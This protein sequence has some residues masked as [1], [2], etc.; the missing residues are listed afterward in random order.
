MYLQ[1][2]YYNTLVTLSKEV[3]REG[4][5]GESVRLLHRL[6]SAFPGCSDAF[7]LYGDA[8]LENGQG[9]EAEN[10][11][12]RSVLI[13]PGTPLGYLN[14]ARLYIGLDNIEKATQ[15]LL[16][17][18]KALDKLPLSQLQQVLAYRRTLAAGLEELKQYHP[19]LI[20][21]E[22]C[23]E[24]EPNDPV[25]H[26]IKGA[27]LIK[28]NRVDEAEVALL[29]SFALDPSS[30][31]N[32]QHLV[33][34]Y[35]SRGVPS[36]ALQYVEKVSKCSPLEKF[37]DLALLVANCFEAM[38]DS[39]TA[40][41]FLKNSLFERYDERIS[42]RVLLQ[43]SRNKPARERP[44]KDRRLLV[45]VAD[46]VRARSMNMAESL[47]AN[48]WKVVMLCNQTP[49]FSWQSYFDELHTYDS[50]EHA[51][52]LAQEYN[53]CAYHIF[54]G[55][56]DV[57]SVNFIKNKPG[58][59]IFD[60][61]DFIEGFITQSYTYHVGQLQHFCMEN[62]DAICARDL[63]CRYLVKKLGYS[64]SRKTIF[65]SDYCTARKKISIPLSRGDA[66]NIHVVCCGS[67]ATSKSSLE[68]DWG[69]AAIARKFIEHGIHFHL[70]PHPAQVQAKHFSEQ[71]SDFIELAKKTPL[72]KLHDP[73]PMDKLA[74][75]ISQYH[76]GINAAY[77]LTDIPFISSYTHAH[78]NYC[79]SA[80]NTEYL[81]AGLP[82]LINGDRHRFQYWTFNRM[83]VA[84]DASKAFFDN[85]REILT[86]FA[87]NPSVVGDIENAQRRYSHET[88]I[89]R[90]I[91]FYEDLG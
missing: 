57:L 8:L 64:L 4:N 82:L 78:F 12:K 51:L 61:Y 75:E 43:I 41:Q 20:L 53:P 58:K 22:T 13:D 60:A 86:Q 69:Y 67:I 36:T 23:R 42:K 49:F 18:A 45:F 56:A 85:P 17:G 3:S 34:L 26:R 89:P 33:E 46:Q 19:A 80:R 2:D 55:N 30:I 88:H 84:I 52:N 1:F 27:L 44:P 28:L 9:E 72:F 63:R 87:R 48:G 59:I 6:T 66:S 62:A 5:W 79:S 70:Y 74:D 35:I 71:F 16:S 76:F 68:L 10:A 21:I 54:S 77:A 7:N 50:P 29:Q 11:F 38:G 73:V 91:K 40:L 47:R 65:F 83:K 24:A 15:A 25:N 81:D 14:L 31:E 37:P 90:L 32:L 39:D